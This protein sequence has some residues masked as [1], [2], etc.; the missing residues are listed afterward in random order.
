MKQRVRVLTIIML[1]AAV[2]AMSSC[3]RAYPE[4]ASEEL[5]SHDWIIKGNNN[6]VS[7][8]LSFA[9]DSFI[10]EA[11]TADRKTIKLSGSFYVD[12]KSITVQTGYYDTII[13]DYRLENDKLIIIYSGKEL[14]FVKK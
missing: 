11:D 6:N 10:L 3:S 13:F 5:I 8:K 12:E 4:T 9:D 7:G 2:I 14:E 1:F